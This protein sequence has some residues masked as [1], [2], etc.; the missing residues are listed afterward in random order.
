MDVYICSSIEEVI[1]LLG[2]YN[3]DGKVISGGTDMLIELR[4]ERISPKALIDISS[5]KELKKIKEDEDFIEIGAGV[6]YTQI[7][8]D[9]LFRDKLYGLNKACRLV[10]SPQIRN[11]GT[12][13]G[14]IAHG[15]PAADSI[16]A[17]I[18]LES[19]VVLE[20]KSGRRE[21]SV[22]NFFKDKEN[23]G[24]KADELLL[25][26]R[27]RN[28]NENQILSFSK[29]GLRKALAIS[30]IS[31]ATLIEINEEGKVELAKVSSG[32]LGRYPMRE[33]EVEKYLLG[34][35]FSEDV[36]DDSVKV[37]Q[38]VMDNRLGGRST[39]PYKRVAV[40]R[41]LKEALKDG[42]KR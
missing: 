7:V 11:K 37:L 39:L 4:N 40:E 24:I 9:P 42:M 30:R 25:A 16:P 17:L 32:S 33:P 13:G 3:K 26:I 10:G 35:H 28:P 34:K 1:E 36:L 2:K 12:I 21:V 31:I 8:E 38:E 23:Y 14:N 15:S 22:E 41:V 19:T 27:F 6:S 29:L 20:N 5:I 18:C